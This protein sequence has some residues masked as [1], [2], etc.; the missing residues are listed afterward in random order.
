MGLEALWSTGVNWSGRG[1]LWYVKRRVVDKPSWDGA[2]GSYARG[3]FCPV[4]LVPRESDH[5]VQWCLS[6]LYISVC[7]SS[8]AL[9]VEDIIT[10]IF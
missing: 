10:K 4:K 9:V 1:G 3:V 2:L 6:Y 7:L 8:G 5:D